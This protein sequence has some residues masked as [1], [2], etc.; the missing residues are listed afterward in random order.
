MNVPPPEEFSEELLAAYADGELGAVDRALVEQWLADHPEMMDA[1]RDQRELSASNIALWDA[2]E[3]PEPNGAAWAAVRRE[4][5]EEVCP[6]VPV[7]SGDRFRIQRAA[8]WILGGLAISGVAAA[9]GWVVF[10]PT[11]RQPVT[12]NH[13]PTVVVCKPKTEAD[14]EVAPTPPIVT[15]SPE[16]DPLAAIAILPMP[17]DDDVILDRVPALRGGRLPIGRHPVPGML[18]LASVADVR[19][20]E[21]SPSLAWPTNGE[22]KMIT[23]PGDAPMIFAAKPR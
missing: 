9:I 20:E 7:V 18:T 21:V 16:P 8:G 17:T 10:A 5:E 4:I 23:A 2:A 6:P 13:T 1:V 15:P 14:P 3:P 11:P 12:E 22:P 19:L